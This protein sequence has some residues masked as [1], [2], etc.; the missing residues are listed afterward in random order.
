ME[1]KQL[2]QKCE[3]YEYILTYICATVDE[4]RRL[5][6]KRNIKAT[7]SLINMM[8]VAASDEG[9]QG[10]QA[11]QQPAQVPPQPVHHFKAAKIHPGSLHFAPRT[12][13][14]ACLH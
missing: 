11:V 9:V 5:E 1:M 10:A 3:Q 4:E 13:R 2:E 14:R 6:V 8:K 12:F 7:L